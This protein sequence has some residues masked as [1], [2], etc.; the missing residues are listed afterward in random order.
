LLK[1][2]NGQVELPKTLVITSVPPQRYSGYAA[3]M[4]SMIE[5][6]PTCFEE[7]I[8]RKSWRDIMMEEYTSIIKNDV[9]EIVP[10]PQN[11]SIVSSKW[12]YK[13]KHA[14]DGSVDKH[15]ARFV[16]RGFSQKEGVDYEETFA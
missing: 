12:I 3:L 16:A 8:E 9:W 6:G 11:K 1:E 15:K 7:A 5:L 4:S 14:T 10:R 2:A 13:L